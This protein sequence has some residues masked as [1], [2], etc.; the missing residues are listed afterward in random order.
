MALLNP[1]RIRASRRMVAAE[2][3]LG[4]GTQ[5]QVRDLQRSIKQTLGI[6]GNLPVAAKRYLQH[7]AKLIEREG[8][9]K[10]IQDLVA[11]FYR[12]KPRARLDNYDKRP[13]V[14]Y[15][16]LKEQ[17]IS[18]DDELVCEAYRLV[19]ERL[20]QRVDIRDTIFSQRGDELL[21]KL[22]DWLG[23]AGN[24][25]ED[26]LLDYLTAGMNAVLR[27]RPSLINSPQ[28]L[29]GEFGWTAFMEWVADR[30]GGRG[31]YLLPTTA[32]LTKAHQYSKFLFKIT[33]IRT[34]L[35][36]QG[37]S[38]AYD[39]LGAAGTDMAQLA[40]ALKKHNLSHLANFVELQ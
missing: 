24:P 28:T 25:L 12:A 22:R 23:T 2:A 5:T 11:E 32:E 9:T 15:Y 8:I 39:D 37:N 34:A 6:R 40:A 36:R 13:M 21:L 20:N 30:W 35:L 7:A 19:A 4:R 18:D 10:P 17:R 26:V 38:Q 27:F 14:F 16:Y 1:H 3:R 33:A 31:G 29:L